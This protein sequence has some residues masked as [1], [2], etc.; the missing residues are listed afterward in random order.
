[1]KNNH[2]EIDPYGEENWDDDVIVELRR[3]YSNKKNYLLS[4]M[5]INIGY[6]FLIAMTLFGIYIFREV[7]INLKDLFVCHIPML[8]IDFILLLNFIFEGYDGVD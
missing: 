3:P 2:K 4:V 5:W 1:M 6:T 7:S 8:I